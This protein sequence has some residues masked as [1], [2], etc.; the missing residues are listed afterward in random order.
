MIS[1][2]G[3]NPSGK[4]DPAPPRGNIG[5]KPCKIITVRRKPGNPSQGLIAAGGAIFPCAL[6]RGGISAR[7]RE[8]DGAT[9]LADMRPERL[10]Y[11]PER[12]MLRAARLPA[13]PI[14]ADSG[15]CDA[16]ADRNYNRFV[17][18]PYGSSHETMKRGDALY[19]CCVVLDWNRRP[20][21]RG[22]GSAIFL[23]MARPGFAPTEGCIAVTKPV[24]RR[25]LHWL[26]PDTVIRVMP[27]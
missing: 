4:D 26:T 5:R 19:D 12:T 9:P 20:R 10:Y 25:L 22:A 24:M 13:T 17:R 16:P 11:R 18:L 23:H 21:K 1:V 7:K 8:G 3:K 6:G 15:W 27:S 14:R 2:P